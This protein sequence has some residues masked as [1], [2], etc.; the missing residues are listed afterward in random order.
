MTQGLQPAVIMNEFG[1][2]SVDGQL[3]D[4]EIPLNELTEGCICC[5]MKADVSDQLHQLYLDY[6]PDIVFIECSGIAEPLAVVDA[7]LTPILAPFTRITYMVGIV[8]AHMYQSLKSYPKD[9]QGL[10]YEQLSHC[11]H[12]FVNKID[13]THVNVTSQLL[14]ELEIINPEA[15]IQVGMY[16]RI[17]LPKFT[18][19]TDDNIQT[20]KSKANHQSLHQGIHHQYIDVP[21]KCNK[22]QF[23]DYLDALPSNIYRM[24][25]FIQF[26]DEPHTYL[27][28]YMQDQF[29][30][31]P[32]AFEKKSPIISC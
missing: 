9:I 19:T 23:I 29:E 28:Q 5:A 10:F 14:K 3:I 20:R 25:G 22:L 7:C 11:S 12:L 30:L 24:K 18:Q 16:G 13:L 2:Q 4:Q 15:D 31:T 17:T 1:K 6:Q 27:V 26:I 32:I 21:V 8:D